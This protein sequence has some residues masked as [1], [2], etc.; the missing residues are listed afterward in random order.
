MNRGKQRVQKGSE[1]CVGR[2]A[3]DGGAKRKNKK[4]SNFAAERRGE[5]ELKFCY[6]ENYRKRSG[7]SH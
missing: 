4:K 1:D 7:R 3:A 2:K 6:S 5:K